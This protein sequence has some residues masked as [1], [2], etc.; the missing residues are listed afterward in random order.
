MTATAPTPDLRPAYRTDLDGLRGVAITLVACFHVWFGKVSGGV[1]V[2]LTLSGYFFIGSLLRHAIASADPVATFRDTLNP[3]PRLSRLLRRLLPA[4]ITVLI[5]VAILTVTMLP[6]TRWVNIGREVIASALYYQNYYLAWNSQDYLA[7]SSANSPL[8]HLWSMSMQGQF[9]VSAMLCGLILAALLKLLG[10]ALRAFT[11]PAVIRTVFGVVV[12]V[13]A[14]V[15]FAHATVQHGVNQPFNYYDTLARLWEPLVGGLLAIWMPRAR[16]PSWLRTLVTVGA[17]ALIVSCGWWIDGV[18]EYPGPMAWVPVG[19]TLLIIASGDVPGT[20][21]SA[22]RVLAS[23]QGVWLGNLAYALYLI[24]WPLL[25]FYLA[26][27]ESDHA[28][29]VAGACILAVSLGLAWLTK[30]Y[31]EDPLRGGQRSPLAARHWPG[32][33]RIQYAAVLT[34]L[35]VL[36]AACVGTGAKLWERHMSTVTV[37]TTNLDPRLYP[38][39]RAW[40]DGIPVPALDPQPTPL[41]AEFDLAP[42][43]ADEVMADFA[44]LDFHV[45]VY[46]DPNATRTLAVAGGSH[47]EMWVPALDIIGKRNGFKVTT[48]L[49]MGCPLTLDENPKRTDGTPYPECARWVRTVLDELERVRPDAVF[50]NSTRPNPNGPADYVPPGYRQVFDELTAAGLPVV[51]VRDTP[52]PHR[53]DGRPIATPSCLAAG[54]DAQSCGSNRANSLAP[55]DPITDYARGNPLLYSIDLSDSVCDDT[56][57]PAVVGNIIVYKDNDHLGATYVRSLSSALS[58]LLAQALPWTGPPFGPFD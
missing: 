16:V 8:Q 20:L 10:T 37:D 17:L 32:R 43:T 39:A 36:G 53:D 14:A 22:N 15:S 34:A 33:P 6:Q 29:I 12:A 9:F 47:A 45:G 31:I 21:P 56:F 19:A 58:Q 54:G 18:A 2:F 46:G 7:A 4:L 49:K 3:W 13:V 44:D 57:C 25:I 50:T 1:D 5:G 27:V 28:S 26:Y 35:L 30:R 24:H 38:G 11:R 41:A 48:Y 23:R 52:W 42:T 40:T 55:I 51:G